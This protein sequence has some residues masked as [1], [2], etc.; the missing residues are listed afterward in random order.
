MTNPTTSNLRGTPSVEDRH[1]ASNTPEFRELLP[2]NWLGVRRARR[3]G[4]R[5]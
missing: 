1:K 2:K 5:A 3:E 4:M